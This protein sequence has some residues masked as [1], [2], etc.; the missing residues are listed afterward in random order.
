MRVGG[1]VVSITAFK[2]SASSPNPR[3]E[4]LLLKIFLDAA[5]EVLATIVANES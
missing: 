3:L 4:Y 5:M 2:D 1:I